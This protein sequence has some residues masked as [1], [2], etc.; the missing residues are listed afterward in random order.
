VKGKAL[1]VHYNDAYIIYPKNYRAKI[2]HANNLKMLMSIIPI[3]LIQKHHILG[4][5]ILML[6]LL[7]CLRRKLRLHQPDHIC[8]S[9]HFMHLMCLLTNPA[10]LLPNMLD[11]GTRHQDLC[12][13]PQG[14]CY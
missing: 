3:P 1:M 10:K 7:K 12:L 9:I 14:A 11:P 5:L 13:D 4:I 6:K 2:V 8:I